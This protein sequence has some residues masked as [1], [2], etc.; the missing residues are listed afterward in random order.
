M[1]NNVNDK[2][3]LPLRYTD[4]DQSGI[5][6]FIFIRFSDYVVYTAVVLLTARLGAKITMISIDLHCDTLARIEASFTLLFALGSSLPFWR[7][8]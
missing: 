2:D 6:P 1:S 8:Y 7:V 3:S 5:Y 4:D